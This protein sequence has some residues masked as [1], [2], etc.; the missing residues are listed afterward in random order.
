MPFRCFLPLF[1]IFRILE[2]LRSCP[3]RSSHFEL[4]FLHGQHFGQVG[5]SLDRKAWRGGRGHGVKGAFFVW[6]NIFNGLYVFFLCYLRIQRWL[7]C[8]SMYIVKYI[9]N[10]N[11]NKRCSYYGCKVLWYM[12]IWCMYATYEWYIVIRLYYIYKQVYIYM[13]IH[14]GN[15][16]MSMFIVVHNK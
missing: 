6:G 10:Y 3:N 2:V 12:N 9:W 11:A 1:G 4:G 5:W 14:I 16:W 13:Y 7:L 8:K 15:I